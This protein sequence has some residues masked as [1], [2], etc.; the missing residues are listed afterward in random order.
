MTNLLNL[1]CP[2]SPYTLTKYVINWTMDKREHQYLSF[3]II[4]DIWRCRNAWLFEN[5]IPMVWEV[6]RKPITYFYELGTKK[7][8]N[9]L[10]KIIHKI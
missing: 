1:D 8:V 6:I 2:G 5:K 3:Y 10:R 9:K 4:W 7:T